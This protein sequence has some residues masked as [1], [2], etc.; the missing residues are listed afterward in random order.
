MKRITAMFLAC[1]MVF[2]MLTG[3]GTTG[4][5]TGNTQQPTGG[6]SGE[7]S[8][9]STTPTEQVVLRLAHNATAGQPLDTAANKVSEMMKERTNGRV[10]IQVY[11]ANVLG[12]DSACRDMLEEGTL[13]IFIVG[14]GILAPWSGAMNLLHVPYI[15]KTEEE[16]RAVYESDWCVE[17]MQEP[18]LAE[19]NC[20]YLDYWM[21]NPRHF[22]SKTPINSVADFAGLKLRLPT[23]IQA[24]SDAWEKL[25]TLLVFFGLEDTYTGLQNGTCDA[26]EMPLDFLDAYKYGEEA[27]YL[28]KTYHQFYSLF[29]MANENSYQ[30]LTEEEKAILAEVLGV[31]GTEME[32]ELAKE[33][34]NYEK[35]MV[36]NTGVIVSEMSDEMYNAIQ[37]T[38]A[39][40]YEE[41]KD[42]WG[43]DCYDGLMEILNQYR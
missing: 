31:C 14:A 21:Q 9:Q 33:D 2:A 3:C 25:G 24:R 20:R 39:P 43:Q 34:S 10:D 41:D 13:D 15:I 19:H 29:V 7:N 16:M 26:V 11:G 42:I 18:F 8:G 6:T 27:P 37:E 17:Y 23:G 4:N 28:T 22:M 5:T 38:I 40:V 1:S 35:N 36:E 30:K 32:E 12:S